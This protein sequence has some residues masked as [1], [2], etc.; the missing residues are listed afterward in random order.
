CTPLSSTYLFSL[1][2]PTR[3]QISPFPYTTLF[4]SHG[5]RLSEHGGL[6]LDTADAPA[7]H[8]QAVDHRG[9]RVGSDQGVRV[10]A[11]HTAYFAG[12]DNPRQVLDID[13][14]H[15]AG[16]RGHHLEV[17]DSGLEI[18]RA[19]CRAREERWGGEGA[20]KGK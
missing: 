2:A 8:A 12:H 6:G 19:S 3:P 5:D 16:A 13:L 7:Q 1:P 17:V 11:Q 4:R 15:D 10:G 14:V 20:V 18:G 9:V